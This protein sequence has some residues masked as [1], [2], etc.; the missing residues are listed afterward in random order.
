MSRTTTKQLP[1]TS[2]VKFYSNFLAILLVLTGL[3]GGVARAQLAGK[4]E[5]KGTVKD[6]TGAVVAGATVTATEVSTG[7]STTRPTNSSGL[8]DISPLDAGVYVVTV[9]AAGFEKQTQADVHVNALEIADYDPVLTVGSSAE[10][11]TVSTA[12]PAL[13]TG[14]AVLGATM[15]QDMYSALPIQMG[16]GGNYDQ[17]RATDFAVLMPGVQGNETNGNATTNTGVVNGSGSR[18]AASAV[19][20]NGLERSR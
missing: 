4:G 19:Y 15:E 7:V 13:E 11:V 8:Y 12:P 1:R 6:P 18:G 9:T 17:R 10:T 5:V 3:A 14:N 16:G 2:S 20:V